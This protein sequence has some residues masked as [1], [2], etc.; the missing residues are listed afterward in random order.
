MLKRIRSRAQEKVRNEF[1][2]EDS[3]ADNFLDKASSVNLKKLNSKLKDVLF[4]DE[5]IQFG[6]KLVR[7]LFVFT[8][9]RLILIDKQGVTGVKTEYFSIPYRSITHF[10]IV[11]AGN[12]DLGAEL[13]IWIEELKI[14]RELKKNV[15]I[16]G[17]QRTLAYFVTK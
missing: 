9:H 10:S 8:D 12:F 2:Q 7:D 3:M 11:T 16:I 15:D 6:F 14:E 17:L 13:T 5:K 4:L 1:F